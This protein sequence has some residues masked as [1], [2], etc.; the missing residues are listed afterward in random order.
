[1]SETGEVDREVVIAVLQANGVD[2]HGQQEGPADMLV[3]AKGDRIEGQRL[4]KMVNR[5]MIHYLSRQFHIP[6]HYFYNPLMGSSA[7]PD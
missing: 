4:P 5:K 7:T 6:I 1:M 2:V 3:L